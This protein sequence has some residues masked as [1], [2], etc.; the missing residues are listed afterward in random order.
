MSGPD[1]FEPD[2]G[3]RYVVITQPNPSARTDEHG[4]GDPAQHE[5]PLTTTLVHPAVVVPPHN[6]MP[7]AAAHPAH[8]LHNARYANLED[9][10]LRAEA[11]IL[12]CHPSGVNINQNVLP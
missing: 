2:I 7:P 12:G 4:A 3:V 9:L 5:L 10:I 8:P 6:H 11:Q 1:R